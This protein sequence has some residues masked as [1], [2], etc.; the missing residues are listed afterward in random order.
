[1]FATCL[2]ETPLFRNLNV[3]V[4]LGLNGNTPGGFSITEAWFYRVDHALSLAI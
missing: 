4:S 1:M 3:D 2:E